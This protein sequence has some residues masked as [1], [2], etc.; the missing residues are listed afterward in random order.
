MGFTEKIKTL[1]ENPCDVDENFNPANGPAYIVLRKVLCSC[2][3][4]TLQ[5]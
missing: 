4:R 1:T 3:S 5:G 2:E